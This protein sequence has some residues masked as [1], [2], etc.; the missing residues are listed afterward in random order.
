VGFEGDRSGSGHVRAT[1]EIFGVYGQ[2]LTEGI[3]TDGQVLWGGP[4][5]DDLHGG[6][7]TDHGGGGPGEDTC[8]AMETVDDC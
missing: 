5:N 2:A 1:G 6:P 8:I 3:S 7:G 4:V